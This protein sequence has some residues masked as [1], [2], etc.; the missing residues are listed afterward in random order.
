MWSGGDG[1][2]RRL[3]VQKIKMYDRGSSANGKFTRWAVKDIRSSQDEDL[4]RLGIEEMGSS[5][6]GKSPTWAAHETQSS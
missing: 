3:R 5:R 6:D 2:F 1:V 4:R